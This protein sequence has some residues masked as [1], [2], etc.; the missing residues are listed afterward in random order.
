MTRRCHIWLL[1]SASEAKIRYHSLLC[2]CYSN[3]NLII[4][5]GPH[6]GFFCQTVVLVSEICLT[7]V[8]INQT[9]ICNAIRNTVWICMGLLQ[10][11]TSTESWRLSSNCVCK[12]STD[13]YPYNWHVQC[14][15]IHAWT[16]QTASVLLRRWYTMFEAFQ[17][18]VLFLN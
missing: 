12:I 15:L 14:R 18:D 16:K 1:W 8:S 10:C 11:K 2:Q 13:T 6:G 7:S 17:I 5:A 3:V 9:F 4:A